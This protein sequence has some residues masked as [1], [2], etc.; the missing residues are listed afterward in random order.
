MTDHI[1]WINSLG[2]V[3]WTSLLQIAEHYLG[4][5]AAPTSTSIL[6][7][8]DMFLNYKV[9]LRRFLSEIR[10]NYVEKN[11]ILDRMYKMVRG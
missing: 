3:R 8:T 6:P 1:D 4:K 11:I 2:K 7:P 9:A 10:D 5:K